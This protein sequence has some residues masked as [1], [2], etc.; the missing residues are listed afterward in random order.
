MQAKLTGKED[1]WKRLMEIKHM[2]KWGSKKRLFFHYPPDVLG[3]EI[4]NLP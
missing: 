3:D 4:K 1:L 2:R